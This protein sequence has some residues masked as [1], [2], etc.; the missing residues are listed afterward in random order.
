MLQKIKTKEPSAVT[1]MR[2]VLYDDEVAHV[3]RSFLNDTAPSTGVS[4]SAERYDDETVSMIGDLVHP[5][6]VG[7]WA[8]GACTK[9]RYHYLFYEQDGQL[10]FRFL[11]PDSAA[12]PLI[13]VQMSL[14]MEGKIATHWE[15]ETFTIVHTVEEPVGSLTW[16]LKTKVSFFFYGVIDL[17]SRY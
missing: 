1:R 6:Y 4:P 5:P 15:P 10:H 7:A 8:L 17:Q 12:G 3:W 14:S 11:V 2:D 16:S 13:H 9:R